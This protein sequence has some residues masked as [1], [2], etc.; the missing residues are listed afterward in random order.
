MRIASTRAPVVAVRHQGGCQPHERQHQPD[1]TRFKS[2]VYGLWRRLP[3][4]F[5]LDF[6][7]SRPIID[8]PEAAA[9]RFSDGRPLIGIEFRVA[10]N[11]C[12]T[13]FVVCGRA[14]SRGAVFCEN[15]VSVRRRVR[16]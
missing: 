15:G 9:N 11:T 5:S 3:F 7:P 6:P 16:S 1:I 10:V 14:S 12:A 13:A 4:G 2:A 8:T